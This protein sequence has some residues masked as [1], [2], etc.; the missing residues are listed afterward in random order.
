MRRSRTVVL[1]RGKG[2]GG[3]SDAISLRLLV[4]WCSHPW[5]ARATVSIYPAYAIHHQGTLSDMCNA[6]F[7]Y[8]TSGAGYCS[9]TGLI[10]VRACRHK[11]THPDILSTVLEP[12]ERGDPFEMII[13]EAPCARKTQACASEAGKWQFG[14][15]CA[16]ALTR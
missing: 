7:G 1:R 3:L 4:E 11:A 13:E 12:D 5:G 14:C 9:Y 10:P 16:C 2:T 15:F 6:A 8:T